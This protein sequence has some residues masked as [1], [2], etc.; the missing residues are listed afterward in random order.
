MIRSLSLVVMVIRCLMMV[1]MIDRLL[2]DR[3]NRATPMTEHLSDR[4]HPLQWNGKS[5]QAHQ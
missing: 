5:K 4:R 3:R 2:N 1:R